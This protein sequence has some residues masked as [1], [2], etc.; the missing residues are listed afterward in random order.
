MKKIAMIKNGVV[1]NIALWDDVSTW[2][3]EGYELVD[4]TSIQCDIGFLY[5]N[6]VFTDP[7]A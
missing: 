6:D 5:E 4:V 2:E 1:E 3:P 7:L